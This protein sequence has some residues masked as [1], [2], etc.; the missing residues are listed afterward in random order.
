M[1]KYI[2]EREPRFCEVCGKKLNLTKY[3]KRKQ[4]DEHTGAD[5]SIY[6][7]CWTCPDKKSFWWFN[8][9]TNIERYGRDLD[10]AL[11]Q[12]EYDANFYCS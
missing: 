1:P 5:D 11:A 7:F 12:P 6:K 3:L 9:H 4:Y 8:P 10:D 2:R